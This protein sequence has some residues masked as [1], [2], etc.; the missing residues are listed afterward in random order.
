MSEFKVNQILV[1]RNT[2]NQPSKSKSLWKVVYVYTDAVEVVP[3]KDGKELKMLQGIYGSA[4]FNPASNEEIAAG[5]RIDFPTLP[6]P[7]G[8]LQE[9]YPEFAKVLHENFLELLGDDSHIENHISPNCK[10]EDV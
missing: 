7:V 1:K 9:L 2:F 6:K 10:V 8:S 3:L 4:M 5:H